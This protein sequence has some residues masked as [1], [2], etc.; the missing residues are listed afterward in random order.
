MVPPL[1][2]KVYAYAA[3]DC[4]PGIEGVVIANGLAG[5]LAGFT[6]TL[7]LAFFVLS[8]ALVAVTVTVVFVVT[9][10]AVNIPLPE[11]VPAEADHVTDVLLDPDTV[12]E[13]CCPAPAVTEADV[14]ETETLTVGVDG[15]MLTNALALFVGSAALVARTVTAVALVTVGAVKAPELVID[16]AVADQVT[17][18][19][20]V[21]CTVAENCLLLPEAR[22]T[23]VG[24]TATL[25]V[26][27]VADPTAM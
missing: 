9:E 22:L 4:A 10:G 6:E 27:F 12:A 1:A 16:P 18:V 3:P 25:T 11:I 15:A 17:A 19:L 26:V 8:A 21:P 13:N 23:L 20:L 14:G 7:T 2:P 5:A 24:V